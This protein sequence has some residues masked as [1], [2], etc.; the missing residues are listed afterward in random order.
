[1]YIPIGEQV[2]ISVRTATETGMLAI[3]SND[4]ENPIQQVFLHGEADM[5]PRIEMS[6]QFQ[7]DILHEVVELTAIVSDDHDD[8]TDLVV[9]WSSSADGVFRY[10]YSR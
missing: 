4:P 6:S 9:E 3:T 5:S 2:P 1:M 10:V 7:G 8:P